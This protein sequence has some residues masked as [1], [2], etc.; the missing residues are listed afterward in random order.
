MAPRLWIDVEDLFEYA[1]MNARPSGIQRLA[2]EIYRAFQACHGASGLV[3]FVRHDG[4]RNSFRIVG[5]S[6]IAA[7]FIDLSNREW[8]PPAA[9]RDSIRPYGPAR[10]FVRALARRLPPDLRFQA[11]RAARLQAEALRACFWLFLALVKSISHRVAPPRLWLRALVQVRPV[12]SQMLGSAVPSTVESYVDL[13]RSGD[14][15]LVIGAPWSHVDYAALVS[16]H[17]K[18]Y[19]IR[20]ALLAYDLIPLRHP[21][22]CDRGLV[23]LFRT[24]VDTMIPQC[25][26]MFAISRATAADVTAYARELGVVLPK[27]IVTLPI[28]TGFSIEPAVVAE[29]LRKSL[30]VSGSYALI[31]STIEPRKNHLL[32]FR[33]WQR[34]LQELPPERVPSLV[35]AGRIGWL[36]EDLMQQIANTDYL[37]GKLVLIENPT[38]DELTKLYKGCLFT[39]FPSLYEGWGLPVTESLAYG[40]PCLMSNRT[41]LPEAGGDLARSFDPDNLYEA[42]AAVR[43][44]ITD[45]A[46]LAQWEM[47][48][49]RKFEPVPW[50]ATV[51]AL[52]SGLNH[53]L[54]CSPQGDTV[55]HRRTCVTG[56]T[57]AEAVQAD[58]T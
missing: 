7:L 10:Q 22:W 34:L 30:P 5:W 1:R 45:R 52:L 24:W 4:F 31:V 38:D 41:S 56:L 46:R 57:I 14:V 11:I 49:R 42:Y 9:R 48:V 27:P 29:R 2:F 3:H 13:V 51:E 16:A 35:F 19:G 58:E 36:V 25:D 39:L 8:V 40:K 54:V 44:V 18:K 50:S 53:P 23:R 32:L 47:Q 17:R 37:N 15:L 26:I 55:S 33:I 6:D 28:G 12:E 21:E 20:C 43:E